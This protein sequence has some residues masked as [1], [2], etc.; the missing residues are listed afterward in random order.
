MVNTL[1]GNELPVDHVPA[2]NHDAP[3]SAVHRDARKG[4]TVNPNLIKRTPGPGEASKGEN[5]DFVDGLARV[6]RGA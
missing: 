4:I 3:I 5:R 2:P 1:N 6:I